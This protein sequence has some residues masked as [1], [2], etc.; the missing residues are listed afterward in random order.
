MRSKLLLLLLLLSIVPF[1]NLIAQCSITTSTNASALTCGVA[2]LSGCG[3]IVYI[4]DGT[5]AMVLTMNAS[6]DLSCLGPIQL[7]V[8]N[9][10]SLDFSP[11]NDYLIL[12]AGSSLILQPGSGLIGGSCNASER[13]Y[14]GTDLIAS[15]N[16]NGPGADYSFL[17]LLAQGGYNIIKGSAS[18][19]SVCGSGSFTLTAVPTPSAG[20]TVRWYTVP[21]GGSAFSI[22][23]PYTTPVISSTT[24]YYVEAYYSSNGFTTARVPVVATVNPLPSAPTLG[25]ITQPTCALSTGSVV[26]NG[27][28]ASGTWT[29]TRSGT[30]SATT[31]GTGTSTTISGLAAGNY[32]FTVSDGTCTSVA[33]GNV[34]IISASAVWNGASWSVAPTSSTHLVFNGNYSSSGNLSGC[35]CTVNIGNVVINAGHVLTVTDAVSVAGGSLTFNNTSSLIQVTN[36]VNSGNI[37]YNRNSTPV[38]LFD[39]TF[40]SSPTSGF[41]TLLNFSPNTLTDKF[42]TYNN[43]W[44][45]SNP[46]V[47]TFTKGIG[48]GIR[49][50]QGTSSVTPTVLPHQ[51]IGV[52]NNGDVD[53]AVI[54]GPPIANRLLGNPYPSTLDAD[55][56]INANIIGSGTINKTISGT[57]YFWTHNHAISGG[58]YTATD[59]ATY[60]LSGGTAVSTGTGNTTAPDQYMAA[61]QGFFIHTVANGNVAFR[62]NM[63]LGTNNNNFYRNA[64]SLVTEKHRIWLNLSQNNLDFNQALVGYVEGAT[65]DYN[66]GYDGLY[67]G[68]NPFALYS[69]IGSETF[70]IQAKA[71]PFSD[72]DSFPLGFKTATAGE[73]TLSIDHMDGVFAGEQNVYL[74]D[75]MLNL[76]HDLRQSP[77]IFSS[78]TGVF[79]DRFVLRY[80]DPTLENG[81]FEV[82]ENTLK[83][84]PSNDEIKI[85]SSIDAVKS[86]I[87]Y[88]V[89]GRTLAAGNNVNANQSVINSIMKSN[90]ALIV[91]VTLE[92]G[93]TVT[94]KIMF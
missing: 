88:D 39:Y 63:R 33:S 24:T 62:N 29:L 94:K 11:G 40:W 14:I 10:A 35:S 56:F 20:A 32:T 89:L 25:T 47:D 70:T 50:P 77:Y 27:L 81:G 55:A 21:S 3:G 73:L 9:A 60:N 19:T 66:P 49:A 83:I 80:T 84:Y 67:F 15:C 87:V 68:A 42:I 22:I 37:T 7:I 5:N 38:V 72:A 48:Y 8:R 58:N 65:N 4:G 53:V 93:P 26:L 92:D 71:L 36:A 79:N 57:L 12:A 17:Q 16:G 45:F 43:A 51:F 64:N 78:A 52:P 28:P 41:Q 44:A 30:S 54:L 2:P 86:Y 46:N 85:E 34:G 76:I 23:N 91:K 69:L 59:Y 6:L 1:E 82:V 31:T 90:Q 74:E 13:I 61:G 18:P 75:R